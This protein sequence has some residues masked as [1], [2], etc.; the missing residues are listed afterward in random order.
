MAR[1]YE[2]MHPFLRKIVTDAFKTNYLIENGLTNGETVI[3]KILDTF[4]FGQN[5]SSAFNKTTNKVGVPI[6]DLSKYKRKNQK[7]KEVIIEEIVKE[8]HDFLMD[9]IDKL[10]KQYQDMDKLEHFDVLKPEILKYLNDRGEIKMSNKVINIGLDNGNAEIKVCY[11]EDKTFKFD[12]KISTK[13]TEYEVFDNNAIKIDDSE[14][15]IIANPY[16]N[17]IK[18]E[19]KAKASKKPIFAFAISKALEELEVT[20]DVATVNICILNPVGENDD[21]EAIKAQVMELNGALLRY[22]TIEKKQWKEVMVNINSVSILAEGIASYLA[23]DDVSN[24][25][26]LIDC[27]SKTTNYI[28]GNNGNIMD[29]GTINLGTD[30]Y[31]RSMAGINRKDEDT[32][33]EMIATGVIEHNS[34]EFGKVLMNILN[35]VSKLATGFS[36]SNKI[37]MTGGGIAL[38]EELG[39]DL[40]VEIISY[41]NNPQFTNVIGAYL[42]LGDEE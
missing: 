21:F 26:C 17:F 12:S 5:P 19:K 7:N 30:N 1:G 39:L 25:V 31:F 29:A 34:E 22:K 38:A 20:E 37:I 10:Y 28:M 18:S 42:Y 4:G 13:W 41:M 32:I 14:Y 2:G 15:F 9:L 23:L 35:E 3:S 33:K 8:D 27:G 6:F 36:K 11:G 24:N 16:D 40:G